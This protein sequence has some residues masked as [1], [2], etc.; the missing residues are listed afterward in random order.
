MTCNLDSWIEALE[1]A[2]NLA[3]RTYKKTLQ[4]T[5]AQ[6]L[7]FELGKIATIYSKV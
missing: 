6:P 2:S 7:K 1:L 4:R 3:A 5:Q